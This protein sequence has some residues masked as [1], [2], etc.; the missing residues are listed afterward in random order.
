MKFIAHLKSRNFANPEEDDA[1]LILTDGFELEM[2]VVEETQFRCPILVLYREGLDLKVP[3]NS[4]SVQDVENHVGKN[5][6]FS[7]Q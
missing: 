6:F 7:E 2:D 3:P 5:M 4:F 1:V